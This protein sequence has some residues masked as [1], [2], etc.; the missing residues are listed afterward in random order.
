MKHFSLAFLVVCLGLSV[1]FAQNIDALRSAGNGIDINADGRV[2]P[3]PADKSDALGRM[4]TN[5][6]EAPPENM[7]RRTTRRAISL[8]KL[9]AEV[10]AIVERYE[11]LPDAIRYLG[12]LTSIEYI[13][14][15]PDENDLLLI[16]PAEGW[17]TDA[18]GNVVGTQTGHPLLVLEDFLT[19]LRLWHQPV[20]PRTV[21]CS[22]EP[23]LESTTR[24][25]RL[26]QQFT[27]ITADNADAYAAALEEAYGENPLTIIGIPATS[28]FARILVASDFQMKRIALGLGPSQVRNIPSYVSLI[29][30]S[31]P[32]ISPR[33][34]LIPEYAAT[35][36]D[37][38]KLTWRLGNVRVRTLT[39]EDYLSPQRNRS[40]DRAALVWCRNM[41]ENYDALARMQPVFG[42]LRNNMRFA[43]VAALIRQENLLQKADCTLTILLDETRLKLVEYPEP[44]SVAFRSVRS[45]SGFS[46]IVASGGVEINPQDA[47]RNNV[48][49]DSRID[50][51]RA[52]LVQTIGDEWWGQ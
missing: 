45:Q 32:N 51:E 52:R 34:W 29:S 20:A 21:A 44:K 37:S 33:F 12:G 9:D 1:T 16:G 7:D 39:H 30:T 40:T 31:R 48:R 28:R 41:E 11:T 10:R 42:E 23:T 36:H 49:L 46:T 24:L 13:V 43:L 47:V 14:A 35:T 18:A 27:N 17:R 50:T 4:M 5:V 22:I 2:V 25:A 8:K 26:H 38:T 3:L 15:V 19:A 6:L